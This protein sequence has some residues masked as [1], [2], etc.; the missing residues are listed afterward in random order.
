[1]IELSH[2]K[3][4]SLNTKYPMIH[5]QVVILPLWTTIRRNF[6]KWPS[7]LTGLSILSIVNFDVKRGSQFWSSE[8]VKGDYSFN[9]HKVNAKY[10]KFYEKLVQ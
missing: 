2:H 3:N 9:F 7:S 10:G 5:E 6:I 1:M 4:T 8:A